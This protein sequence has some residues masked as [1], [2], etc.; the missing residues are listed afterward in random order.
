M[1]TPKSVH[2]EVF[3]SDA[4]K[5]T[6]LTHQP[7]CIV[8]ET[9]LGPPLESPLPLRS[10]PRALRDASELEVAFLQTMRQ[11]CPTTPIVCTV[12]VYVDRNETPHMVQD[13]IAALPRIGYQLILPEV[14]SATAPGRETLT[15]L[16]PGQFVG[17][18]ILCLLPM[19]AE[20]PAETSTGKPKGGT[21]AE[22]V[23][24]AH[25]P[26]SILQRMKM[27]GK[28]KRKMQRRKGKK[29]R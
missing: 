19:K 23:K 26:P 6:T 8:T 29:R 22:K 21:T 10:I 7:D 14:S 17:R 3:I 13:L 9:T 2:S 20:A 1:H 28:G 11:T 5:A 15:Y 25:R 4:C 18:E 27:A 24:K 12:P 16:R